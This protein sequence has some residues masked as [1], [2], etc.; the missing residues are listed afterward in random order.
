MPVVVVDGPPGA[1]VMPAEPGFVVVVPTGGGV[2]PTG[3]TPPMPG[4]YGAG[5]PAA[6]PVFCA[7]AEQDVPIKEAVTSA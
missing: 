7:S 3:G 2:V 6:A 1:A 4:G 5:A